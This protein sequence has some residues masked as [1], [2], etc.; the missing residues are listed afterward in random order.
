LGMERAGSGVAGWRQGGRK[1]QEAGKREANSGGGKQGGRQGSRQQEA[2]S[3][4]WAAGGKVMG[5]RG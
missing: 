3:E 1:W 5:M 4:K 2:D